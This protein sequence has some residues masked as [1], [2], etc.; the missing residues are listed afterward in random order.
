M[1]YSAGLQVGVGPQLVGRLPE[2]LGRVVDIHDRRLHCLPSLVTARGAGSAATQLP[3]SVVQSEL[4]GAHRS[5]SPK[6]SVSVP[7]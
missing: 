4:I 6:E 5:L 1:E 7:V 2:V 3:P